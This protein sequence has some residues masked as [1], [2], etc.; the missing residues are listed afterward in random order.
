MVR[1]YL[2]NRN[3]LFPEYRNRSVFYLIYMKIRYSMLFQLL[4]YSVMGNFFF[5]GSMDHLLSK[6]GVVSATNKDSIKVSRCIALFEVIKFNSGSWFIALTIIALS[7]LTI[8]EQGLVTQLSEDKT[9]VEE[10]G[11]NFF[12]WDM[13]NH[14]LWHDF[15]TM[16]Y[17]LLFAGP[18]IL[19][20]LMAFFVPL[21][22]NPYVLGCPFHP[23]ICRRRLR[24]KDMN[25]YELQG[26]KGGKDKTVDLH[27]FMK[28]DKEM[29]RQEG[30][31]DMELGSLGTN[32]F[33][34]KYPLS[35]GTAPATGRHSRRRTSS[36]SSRL[37]LN[38]P[39]GLGEVK[40]DS[41]R[42]IYNGL[43]AGNDRGQP[44]GVASSRQR[45][46]S[47]NNQ[48]RSRGGNANQADLAMI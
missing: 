29:Q 15:D 17:G 45:Q 28:L 23:P 42:G 19:M 4:F 31:A 46:R 5:L 32:E 39:Y 40:V 20:A 38:D 24:D 11:W 6:P 41:S 1:M 18:A 9:F 33:G 12:V 8:V 43:V 2:A 7:Y 27:A 37:N 16:L 36:S 22:L 13:E 14:P 44:T 10:D 47:S 30:K 48:R 35:I 3:L 26:G 34:S 21:L 25:P